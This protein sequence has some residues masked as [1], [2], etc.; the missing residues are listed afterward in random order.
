MILHNWALAVC[1]R[2]RA[3]LVEELV[4]A[5][6]ELE[7]RPEYF[8]LI[9]SSDMQSEREK[10]K[11]SLTKLS[12]H[13]S[14]SKYVLD[15]PG[16]PHQR[17]TA[18]ELALDLG[19]LFLTFFDDDIRCDPKF[20]CRLQ[21]LTADFPEVDVWGGFDPQISTHRP[22]KFLGKIGVYPQESGTVASSGLALTPVPRDRKTS[23]QFVSGGMQTLKLKSLGGHRLDEALGFHGEDIEFH[24][25]MGKNLQIASS[26]ELP[27]TH[28]GATL[29]KE[30]LSSRN[31]KESLVAAKLQLVRPDIIK[32][33]HVLIGIIAVST[34]G[35]LKSLRLMEIRLACVH[36]LNIPRAVFSSIAIWIRK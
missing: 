30:N 26:T 29:G 23:V 9:D 8:F 27:L 17:N 6:C 18:I 16:L 1:T 4:P 12:D 25:R 2:N 34:L 36:L 20:F 22:R 5:L 28:L 7:C 32:R 33:P 15:A 14:K 31:L 21:T 24:L 13:I 19:L 35:F 10:N 11:V 3:S